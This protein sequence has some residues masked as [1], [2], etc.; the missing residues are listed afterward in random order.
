MIGGMVIEVID[1]VMGRPDVI[2]V[3]VMDTQPPKRKR[4]DMCAIYVDKNETSLQIRAGDS[5]WWQGNI[6]LW[7][8]RK[9]KE[10]GDGEYD[11]HIPRV[12]FS[13]VQRPD[14]A[15]AL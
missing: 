10:S 3:N 13:G 4:F 9:V 1:N 12:G 7:T 14:L 8:P 2:W 6:A 11:I 15:L 5:I